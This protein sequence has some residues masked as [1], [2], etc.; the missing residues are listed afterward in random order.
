MSKLFPKG[1]AHKPSEADPLIWKNW[2][3]FKKLA[4]S[5]NHS[6]DDFQEKAAKNGRQNGAQVLAAR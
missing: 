5:L 2:A 4:V 1:T 3:E 6:T